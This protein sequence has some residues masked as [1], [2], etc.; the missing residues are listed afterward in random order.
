[1]III[2]PKDPFT[3]I[4]LLQGNDFFRVYILEVYNA[5]NTPEEIKV[6]RVGGRG[7]GSNYEMNGKVSVLKLSWR[8]TRLLWKLF[9]V[10]RLIKTGVRGGKKALAIEFAEY[11]FVAVMMKP[12]GAEFQ[13]ITTERWMGAQI[14]RE[15]NCPVEPRCAA[16]R[17]LSRSL[18]NDDKIHRY[19]GKQTLKI[20]F[21]NTLEY[22]V[23]YFRGRWL[24]RI[25]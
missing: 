12:R 15:R 6:E 20:A 10:L 23:F 3:S 11:R 17:V 5:W 18:V 8:F 22:R 13:R 24:G 4:S 16:I 21:R 2:H 25:R 1:M 19:M 7:K 9:H 14:F